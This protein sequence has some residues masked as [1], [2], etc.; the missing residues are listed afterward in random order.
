MP[1]PRVTAKHD[2]QLMIDTGAL[3]IRYRLGSGRFTADNLAIE[4]ELNGT[5]ATLRWSLV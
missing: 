3:R 5:P 1:S 4:Y 2:G